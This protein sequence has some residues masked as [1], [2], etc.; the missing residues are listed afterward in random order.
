MI[1]FT[2]KKKRTE[3]RSQVN[4]FVVLFIESLLLF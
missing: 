1:G 4:D 2:D 3:N